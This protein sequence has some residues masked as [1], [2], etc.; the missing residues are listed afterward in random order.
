M[1]Q[2]RV[3]QMSSVGRSIGLIVVTVGIAPHPTQ[4]L[5]APD[6]DLFASDC[7][8]GEIPEAYQRLLDGPGWE[9]APG[10]AG[11]AT[12][13]CVPDENCQSTLQFFGCER[14]TA[15]APPIN[16]I[17][18][19]LDVTRC[20]EIEPGGSCQASLC[21]SQFL[22]IPNAFQSIFVAPNQLQIFS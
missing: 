4:E 1:D 17:G 14:T 18:C 10:Y 11:T 21:V 16:L 15:C 6:C 12:A 13:R 20:A 8:E 9:C 5:T 3:D 19:V 7:P 22:I 2:W